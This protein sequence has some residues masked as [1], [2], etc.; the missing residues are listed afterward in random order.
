MTS[1]NVTLH[2]AGRT[3]AGVHA[4]GMTANFNTESTIPCSGFLKGLN[5]LLPT[6]IRI[7]R[8]EDVPADFHA[9]FAVKAKTYIYQF[10]NTSVMPPAMRLYHAHLSGSL[11]INLIS[12]CL[13]EITGR[14]DFSSFEASGSRDLNSR[15]GKGAVRTIFSAEINQADTL[16]SPYCIAISG[17][18]F[19]RHMVRN[20]VG[21]LFEAGRG[22][23]SAAD[24]K[25]IIEAKDRSTAGPTAPAKGLFL[26]EVFY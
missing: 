18:G 26:Q 17:D 13:K 1:A 20:I 11:D 15:H 21:T 19:L 22:K 8:L 4:L 7:L 14:H 24:F 9:R 16:C 6:D 2:G 10:V 3:D 12:T 5:S 25:K 23:I